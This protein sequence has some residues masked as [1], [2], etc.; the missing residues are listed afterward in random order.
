MANVQLDP[1]KIMAMVSD[2]TASPAVAGWH[3]FPSDLEIMGTPAQNLEII[4]R[5]GFKFWRTKA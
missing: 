1:M 3:E 4:E 2:A 5:G